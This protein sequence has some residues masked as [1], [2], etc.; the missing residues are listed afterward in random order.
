M[1]A[2]IYEN[3]EVKEDSRDSE[4]LYEGVYANQDN[5]ENQMPGRFKQAESSGGE[6]TWRICYRVTTV[7]LALV[8]VLLLTAITVVW[9][10]YNNLNT[11][12]SHL[13][14]SNNN[15]MIERDQLQ[16]SYNKPT[17]ERD[18]L[19]TSYNNLMIERD[20]L[21]TSYNNLRIEGDQLQTSYNNLTIERDQLQTSY[22]NLTI[23]R[24]QLQTSY[25][26][27]TIERDQLQTS[28]NNLTIERDQLQT[29]NKNLTT[30]R[31]QL[32]KEKKEVQ[33]L[34]KAGWIYF[35][36]SI[37][38]IFTEQTNWDTS[39]QNCRDRG[40][41][42]VIINSREEQ[43]FIKKQLSS[44]KS[45]IGLSDGDTEGEW[46]WVDNTRLS[47]KFWASGEPNGAKNENCVVTGH[48]TD[49]VLDWA[50]YPCNDKFVW[51]C[52]K[53]ICN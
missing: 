12:Y 23:E 9:I 20:Q 41:D 27:L 31:D 51:I 8:C 17:I 1:S 40:A 36:S 32:Q 16:T 45:W 35:S 52:E 6:T 19:Q 7:C 48:K 33:K 53:T 13:Q 14:T 24:D 3:E 28:Y 44:R 5:L 49:P 2:A 25:N 47:T 15:L 34:F 29:S 37:Y 50:D 21:Q 22:N 11:E 39:R 42:L 46:K 30:E 4:N 26:N 43:E 10:K 38:Y 18:R